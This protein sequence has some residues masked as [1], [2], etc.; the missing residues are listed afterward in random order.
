MKKKVVGG[1]LTAMMITGLFAGCGNNESRREAAD[2]GK[3]R[4]FRRAPVQD[5]ARAET[6][7]I[8]GAKR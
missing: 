5:A 2:A 4:L 3:R 7:K 6:E 8:M 1:I